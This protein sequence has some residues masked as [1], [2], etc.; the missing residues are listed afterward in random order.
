MNSGEIGVRFA[1]S[2]LG[3]DATRAYFG[4]LN[5]VEAAE[6]LASIADDAR[7]R[8]VLLWL[9]REQSGAILASIEPGRAAGV[10]A[11]LPSDERAD[12]LAA[13]DEDPRAAIQA[14]LPA[15]ARRDA[16]RLLAY[17]PDTAGG[18]METEFVA[19]P[20]G[21]SVR[22]AIRDLR[23]NQKKYSV[24]GVQ[25]VYLLDEENRL[26]GVA[27]LRDLMLAA[28][29]SLLSSLVTRTPATVRDTTSLHDVAA[30]FDEHP[31]LALPVVDE[32]GVMLG[33]ISRAD[34]T[35]GEQEEAEDDYRLSQ[36]I[37]GGEELRSMP[38]GIRLR[39][40]SAWLGVN[41]L[42]CLGGAAIVAIHRDTL[43]KAI[44]VAA[45]LPVISATSGN[46]AMQAAAVT[47]RELTLGVIDPAAWRRVLAHEL[48][49]AALMALPL[50]C[51]VGLL[52]NL[53]GAPWTVGAAV[54]IAM[55]LNA[56]IAIGIGATC[57][58]LL[59]RL[60]VDPAL[61]SGPIATTLADVTGFALT[62]TLVAMAT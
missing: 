30:T 61:A 1:D 34:A 9:P 10:I 20:A 8:E 19:Y 15:A 52:S 54:G 11:G 3:P 58:L 23:S 62:L 14:L 41:L 45:V 55:A 43:A 18:L 28:E 22:D 37:V 47:I 39:R 48:M 16:A 29:D 31:F 49:L 42:L 6:V 25:Y 4:T 51:A 2:D 56:I 35:E 12:L 26:F 21:A 50:G 27:P 38:V 36:G 60:S 40:R 24:I 44:V 59:R 7:V 46:A 32:S 53:W 17:P 13:I 33:V 57:P 5:Q